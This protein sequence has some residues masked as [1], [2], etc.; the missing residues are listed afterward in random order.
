MVRGVLVC[1]REG[2]VVVGHEDGAALRVGELDP[3]PV[4]GRGAGGGEWWGVD[5]V[6]VVHWSA[7]ASASARPSLVMVAL[8]SSISV[9]RAVVLVVTGSRLNKYS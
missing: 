4:V 2:E 1:G 8:S 6:V 3:P 7:N 9:S 5:V